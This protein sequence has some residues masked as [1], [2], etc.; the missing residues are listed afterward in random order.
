MSPRDTAVSD[1]RISPVPDSFAIPSPTLVPSLAAYS[2]CRG[3]K[4]ESVG[5]SKTIALPD[6]SS[7]PPSRTIYSS[8]VLVA[9]RIILLPS[10]STILSSSSI[11]RFIPTV[12]SLLSLPILKE[13]SRAIPSVAPVSYVVLTTSSNVV[14]KTFVVEFQACTFPV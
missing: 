2:A 4:N 8:R 13:C 9:F 3:G 11:D 12:E 1:K 5:D 14:V 6:V 7:S 10:A